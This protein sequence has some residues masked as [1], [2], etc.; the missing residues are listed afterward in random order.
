[1][2]KITVDNFITDD[3][4]DKLYISSLIDREN[5]A[6]DVHVRSE[7]KS[8]IEDFCPECELLVNTMDVWARDYMPIQLTKDVFLGY[9]Y[10][11]DYLMDDPKC[12]TNWQLHDVHTQR[13]SARNERFG[14]K[15]VQ[16]PI[17]LDGG[18]VVKAKVNNKPCIIMCDKVLRRT[19]YSKRISAGGGIAGGKTTSVEQK[20]DWFSCPGRDVMTIPL[21]TLTGW[22]GI[23][24]MDVS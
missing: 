22:S 24:R 2:E 19:M 20:W 3:R 8:S 4:T 21:V 23:L 11:P 7:L 9:T 13:Q 5:G 6:L 12:V 18:N 15:V 16:M 10:N 1:M 14:F 17:I